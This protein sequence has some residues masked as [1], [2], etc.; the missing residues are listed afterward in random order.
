MGCRRWYRRPIWIALAVIMAGSLTGCLGQDYLDQPLYLSEWDHAW[1]GVIEVDEELAV[2]LRENPGYPG[3]GWQIVDFDEATLTL[4]DTIQEVA[5]PAAPDDLQSRLTVYGFQFTGKGLGTT[6]LVFEIRVDGE[7]VDT[8]EYQI[9]VVADACSS[10]AGLTAARCRREDPAEDRPGRLSEWDHGLKIPMDPGEE[11]SVGLT[12]NPVHPE[13]RWTVA[14]R[15]GAATVDGLGSTPPRAE[16]NWNVTDQDQPGSFVAVSEFLV[17]M[18]GGT[19]G[20]IVFE[21][22]HRDQRIEVVE[23]EFVVAEG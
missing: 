3:A 14:G 5:Q 6:P 8:A 20:P 21:L 12:T 19:S 7:R 15:G 2:G 9:E 22:L 13:S 17:T 16:G 11:M 18:T 10:P 23:L 4:T 1:L